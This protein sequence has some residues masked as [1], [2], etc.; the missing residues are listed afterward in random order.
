MSRGYDREAEFI[1]LPRDGRHK[2]L[3]QI[4][5]IAAVI[6]G[7]LLGSL[8]KAEPAVAKGVAKASAGN[9]P[10]SA[11]SFN[12]ATILTNGGART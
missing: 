9:S 6:V 3:Y 8:A 5:F 2:W 12:L 1:S 10:T 11:T 4:D 7:M